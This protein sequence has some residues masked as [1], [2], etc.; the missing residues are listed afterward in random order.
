MRSGAE[1]AGGALGEVVGEGEAAGSDGVVLEQGAGERGEGQPSASWGGQDGRGGSHS[2]RVGAAAVRRHCRAGR[3]AQAGSAAGWVGVGQAVVAARFQDGALVSSQCRT[4][5]EA[6]ARATAAAAIAA[7]LLRGDSSS[8]PPP[9][10]ARPRPIARGQTTPGTKLALA[11]PE[12]EARGEWDVRA[13]TEQAGGRRSTTRLLWLPGPASE[14]AGE[15]GTSLDGW[16]SWAFKRGRGVRPGSTRPWRG[17]AG[18]GRGEG[19]GQLASGGRA[20]GRGDGRER[21]EG[22]LRS[23][24]RLSNEAGEPMCSPSEGLVCR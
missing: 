24:V 12:T 2:E 20:G 18:R 14:R 8:P 1:P 4:G 22:E 6:A 21:A 19:D 16:L 13:W 7:A 15:G 17:R 23:W 10:S 9:L 5:R 11:R 3:Q